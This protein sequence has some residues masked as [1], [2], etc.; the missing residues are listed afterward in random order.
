MRP[1]LRHKRCDSFQRDTGILQG[2]IEAVLDRN[3]RNGVRQVLQHRCVVIAF[4]AEKN[5]GVGSRMPFTEID[6][7]SLLGR[8]LVDEKA[9]P[10]SPGYLLRICF[11]ERDSKPRDTER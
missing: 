6:E 7:L 8:T 9:V 1:A 4:G 2:S 3:E 11:D 5:R 10:F